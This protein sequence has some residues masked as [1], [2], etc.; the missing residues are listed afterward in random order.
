MS[1]VRNTVY[2]LLGS[3]SPMLVALV[4]V[5]LYIRYIGAAEYGILTI[6]WLLMGY[7]TYAEFGL[8]QSVANE[9]AR[10]GE[11]KIIERNEVFWTGFWTALIF[12]LLLGV[13]IVGLGIVLVPAWAS[14][15]PKLRV[16]LM[17]AL[18]WLLAAAPLSTGNAVLVGAMDGRQHFKHSNII[19]SMGWVLSQGLPLLGVLIGHQ[20]LPW[21]LALA[22][23]GRAFTFFSLFW[24]LSG[25]LPLTQKILPECKKLPFLLGFGGWVTVSNVAESLL[26]SLDRWLAGG[27]LGA[28]AV[29]YYAVPANL[30]QRTTVLPV[31]LVRTL[32]PRFSALDAELALRET[33]RITIYLGG[34]L[35]PLIG[36]GIMLI[37]PFLR[38]WVG[39]DFANHAYLV[40]PILLLAAWIRAIAYMPDVLLRATRRPRTV[41]SIRVIELPFLFVACWLGFKWLGLPGLAWAWCLRVAFDAA[42]LWSRAECLGKVAGR[43]FPQA[44][45]LVIVY[46]IMHAGFQSFS[47]TTFAVSGC[48]V[49]LLVAWTLWMDRNFWLR[50]WFMVWPKNRVSG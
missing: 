40:A 46:L 4:T 16:E 33:V 10:L 37:D 12:G 13:V 44:M 24:V 41:A 22:T 7:S 39:R 29:A 15:E 3:L 17:H 14:L 32:F 38:L 9:I 48:V 25:L 47:P 8:G 28:Q 18:P 34:I 50:I 31:A 27:F 30:A 1:K 5:P 11:G 19:Q 35:A 2:N 26:S 43:L 49:I 6:A 20:S 45:G 21:L 42:W 23:L 36:V